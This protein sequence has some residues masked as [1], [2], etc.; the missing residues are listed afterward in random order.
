MAVLAIDAIMLF[1][2]DRYC[3]IV[4]LFTIKSDLHIRIFQRPL[5]PGSGPV[6]GSHVELA[7]ALKARQDSV[8]RGSVLS[9]GGNNERSFIRGLEIPDQRLKRGDD[10]YVDQEL[11][12]Y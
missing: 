11:D 2:G 3:E 5:V 10:S 4:S 1:L 9:C 6:V 8:V 12:R 7:I